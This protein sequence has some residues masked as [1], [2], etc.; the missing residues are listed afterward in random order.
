MDLHG[1]NIY[2]IK[3]G[4]KMLDYSANINPLKVPRSLKE[5]ITNNIDKLINY[6]DPNYTDLKEAIAKFTK[7]DIDNIL[8]GNGAVELIFIFIK[9]IKPKKTLIL[10][11][12]F[13]EYERALKLVGSEIDY[14]PYG[15]GDESY[16][17]P[18]DKVKE[19]IIKDYDLLIICNPNNPTGHLTDLEDIKE[20]NK[21]AI[22]NNCKLLI[23]EAFIDFLPTGEEV[24]AK[25]LQSKNICVVR[26]FTKFYAIPG[27]RLG[28][29]F[30][31]DIEL[32]KVMDAIKEPWS[33]NTFAS[34]GGPVM[35]ADREYQQRT[36]R[37]LEEEKEYIYREL[38][39]VEGIKLYK[40]QVNFIL[41]KLLTGIKSHEL[42]E[43]L[44]EKGI[45]IR[46]CQNFRLLDHYHIRLA[47]KDRES[48]ARM[49]EELTKIINSN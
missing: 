19:E 17:T 16:F 20:I 48:N 40:P 45:I 30:T 8:V 41:V 46:D 18:V 43:K 5:S 23:D 32:K 38:G 22:E 13:A 36:Y 1:G 47:I 25:N 27:L 15:I 39:K 37:W 3:D 7:V 9:S 6:P 24:S 33:I 49:V 21:I 29:G 44:L 26:A 35:L 4:D 11:P 28:F 10:G 2:K 12:T 14:L 42:R 34:L 31:W